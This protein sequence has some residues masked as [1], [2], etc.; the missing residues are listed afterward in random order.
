[1]KAETC[2]QAPT[3]APMNPLKS[4]NDKDR[5]GLA[6]SCQLNVSVSMRTDVCMW[7][8]EGDAGCC[9]LFSSILSLRQGLSLKPEL[10]D[11]PNW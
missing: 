1:M 4:G 2:A 6:A 8:T 9:L 5:G 11:W 7:R 10:T 3:T